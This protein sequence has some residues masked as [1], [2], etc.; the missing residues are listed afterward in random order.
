MSDAYLKSRAAR[1]IRRNQGLGCNKQSSEG[2]FM[3][4]KKTVGRYFCVTKTATMQWYDKR[5][6]VGAQATA[7]TGGLAQTKAVFNW[8]A[9]C[10]GPVVP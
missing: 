4:G 8:W 2:S 5:V 6:L 3:V 1:G 10:A 7:R 9:C